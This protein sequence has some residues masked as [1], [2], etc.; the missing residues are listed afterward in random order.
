MCFAV[1]L[2]GWDSVEEVD[3]VPVGVKGAEG[4]ESE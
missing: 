4:G 1:G 3:C 2:E